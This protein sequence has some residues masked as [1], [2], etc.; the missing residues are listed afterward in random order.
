[1]SVTIT[2]SMADMFRLTTGM[3]DSVALL[4]TDMQAVFSKEVNTK[5]VP[6]PLGRPLQGS[7]SHEFMT[8][9]DVKQAKALLFDQY[10]VQSRP[11]W[12]NPKTGQKP[13][14]FSADQSAMAADEIRLDNGVIAVLNLDLPDIPPQPRYE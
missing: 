2:M 1:M 9:E 6:R 4:Q 10:R 11:E 8:P 13:A 12:E 5:A 7:D 3:Y 14:R